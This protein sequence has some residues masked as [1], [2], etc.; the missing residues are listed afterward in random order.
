MPRGGAKKASRG[1]ETGHKPRRW[2]RTPTRW[3][4]PGK[5]APAPSESCCKPRAC[6]LG[7]HPWSGPVGTRRPRAPGSVPALAVSALIGSEK[8][9]L[10]SIVR[11]WGQ[12][13]SLPASECPGLGRM[14]R[15]TRALAERYF[16]GGG[17]G[18]PSC[19]QVLGR[20]AFISEPASFSYADFV[21]SFLLPNLP[22]VF[23]SAFTEGWGGRRLWVTPT[24]RPDFDHL[25]RAYGTPQQRMCSPCLCTSRLTG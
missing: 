9:D 4:R 10:G 13:W 20:V 2:T 3:R 11:G 12:A 1:L 5:S 15:E 22:C 23:S 16:R 14:D 25:L 17:R 6:V 7:G 19:S 18:D 21:R 24:G 8:R